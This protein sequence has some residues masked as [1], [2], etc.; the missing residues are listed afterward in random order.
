MDGDIK[1]SYPGQEPTPTV[2]IEKLF[3]KSFEAPRLDNNSLIPVGGGSIFTNEMDIS[4]VGDFENLQ[5]VLQEMHDNTGIYNL[6]ELKKWL[7]S[8]GIGL[9]EKL[10][11]YLFSFTKILE[12]RYPSSLE[13]QPARQQAYSKAK[14]GEV[15][16]SELFANNTV[17][18]AEIAALAQYYL[19]Q[20]GVES[21]YFSGAVLWD[22]QLEFA[23]EH[24][25]IVI[26]QG[27]H[28]LLFDPMNPTNTTQGLFPSIYTTSANF[29]QEVRR[30]QKRFVPA[31]NV[32]SK[33][34]A[35][36]GVNNGTKVSEMNVV[37]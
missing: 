14:N 8:Q 16:L 22:K 4:V 25:F 18:C 10:F 13:V 7:D 6:P 31:T 23:E 3:G 19:Q 29:D 12:K 2:A 24:S 21:R 26:P 11:A 9:D 20:E 1:E 27:E 37:A 32:L 5:E 17:A 30:R 35:Y 34:Q 28:Q 36:Y 33:K 15:K